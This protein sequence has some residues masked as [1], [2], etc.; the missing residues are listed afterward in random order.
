MEIP[1]TYA[2]PIGLDGNPAPQFPPH[3]LG[4]DPSRV[5]S[6]GV[7]SF[8]GRCPRLL[9]PSPSGIRFPAL[10]IPGMRSA[11]DAACVVA[12]LGSGIFAPRRFYTL[13]LGTFATLALA[14]AAIGLWRQGVEAY[15]ASPESLDR[16]LQEQCVG[17][18]DY[19]VLLDMVPRSPI[20]GAPVR[21]SPIAKRP[22]ATGTGQVQ[23]AK[24]TGASP[25][26]TN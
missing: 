14:L 3:P 6:C 24:K 9:Y 13:L 23:A 18:T 22:H 20:S 26:A 1:S 2:R 19:Q 17:L 10:Y 8:R 11:S 4:S 15:D 21:S 12:S 5:G 7:A 25:C 16:L